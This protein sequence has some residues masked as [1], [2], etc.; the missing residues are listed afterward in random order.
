MD[1]VSDE[2]AGEEKETGIGELLLTAQALL[3]L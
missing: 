2:A 3:L 1:E